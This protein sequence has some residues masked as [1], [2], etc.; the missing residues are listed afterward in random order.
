MD[1]K[2]RGIVL[3]R[4]PYS[5]NSAV[6]LFFTEHS[7]LVSFLVRGLQ[8]S[9]S[10]NAYYQLGQFVELVYRPKENGGLCHI[11]EINIPTEILE[12]PMPSA[13]PF[14]VQQIRFF[15]I[16]IL[17]LCIHESVTDP[18]LFCVILLAF[19]KLN[20][21]QQISQLPLEFIRDICQVLGYAIPHEWENFPQEK[22]SREERRY[23]LNMMLDHLKAHAFPEKSIK[24]LF[25]IDE[26]ND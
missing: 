7:G 12:E 24:S 3:K 18:D 19:Q 17:N 20:R 21:S 11:K 26:L 16:E 2:T 25:I 10:K 23:Q 15:Y 9:K 22:M 8:T 5:D 13:P 14:L 6:V 4:I 1:L